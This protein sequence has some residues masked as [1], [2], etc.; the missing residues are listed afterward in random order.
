MFARRIRAL[1]ATGSLAATLAVGAHSAGATPVPGCE[2]AIA[3]APVTAFEGTPTPIGGSS[4]TPFA[5]T[6]R[7]TVTH[8][9]GAPACPVAALSAHASTR[10][11]TTNGLDLLAV[12]QTLHWAAGDVSPRTVVVSVHKDASLECNEIYA[13]QLTTTSRT[14]SLLASGVGTIVNDDH[15]TLDTRHGWH[16]SG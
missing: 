13:L 11:D 10:H 9:V 15:P 1:V 2:R 14:P 7:T 5:F 8:R 3:V 12:S 6:V 4:Y 16:C